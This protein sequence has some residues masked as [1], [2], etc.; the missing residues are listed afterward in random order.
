MNDRELDDGDFDYAEISTKPTGARVV[1]NQPHDEEFSI[2]DSEQ[3]RA[4]S[5]SPDAVSSVEQGMGAGISEAD[6]GVLSMAGNSGDT[7]TSGVVLD[8]VRSPKVSGHGSP[9]SAALPAADEFPS[10]YD[11]QK[12]ANIPAENSIRQLFTYIGRYQPQRRQLETELKPFIPDYIAAVGDVDEFLKPPRPDG[13]QE[14]LGLR[15]LDEPSAK[16]SDPAILRKFVRSTMKGT[17]TL[18]GDDDFDA[19]IKHDDEERNEKIDAWIASVERLRDS[20]AVGEFKS[21]NRFPPIDTLM[22]AWPEELEPLVRR[23]RIS[24]AHVDVDVTTLSEALCNLL[25]I[26]VYED[27]LESLHWMFMLF[28]E[29]KNNELVNPRE[30]NGMGTADNVNFFVNTG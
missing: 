28:L 15:V 26:P 29:L 10:G 13:Q 25:D 19:A 22:Q 24:N 21:S 6:R 30:T 18:T 11:P 1:T 5:E 17:A 14:I 12:Y 2:S 4:D 9:P 3:H 8:T 16:Q 23:L 20:Q 7:P 27:L